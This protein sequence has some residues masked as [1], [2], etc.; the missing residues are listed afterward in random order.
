MSKDAFINNLS[1]RLDR[2]SDAD[3][4]EYLEFFS[5]MIDSGFS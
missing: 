4:Q 5:E 1:R 3:R 2:L